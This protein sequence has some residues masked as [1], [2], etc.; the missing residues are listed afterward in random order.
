MANRGSIWSLLETNFILP[1]SNPKNYIGVKHEF[2]LKTKKEYWIICVNTRLL[3][4]IDLNV[5]KFI[6]ITCMFTAFSRTDP[7]LFSPFSFCKK[8]QSPSLQKASCSNPSPIFQTACKVTSRRCDF[9]WRLSPKK[10]IV[11]TNLL[12]PIL[13][14][15]GKYLDF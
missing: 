6:I 4:I 11:F 14:C 8:T 5:N 15:F 13:W 3:F 1:N 10:A 2:C 7:F 12:C 9:A